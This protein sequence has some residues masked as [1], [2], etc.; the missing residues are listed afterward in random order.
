MGDTKDGSSIA[1]QRA[2]TD[3]DTST[4]HIGF[5]G[6]LFGQQPANTQI[7]DDALAVSAVGTKDMLLNIRNM[8]EM[9]VDDVAIP[10]ADITSVPDD[11]TLD[12]VVA[13]FRQS[14]NSR[15]PVFSETLDNPLG[16]VHLKDIA[17]N[18]GFGGNGKFDLKAIIRPLIYVPP[19]MPLGALLQKMQSER[20]HMAL[21]IDEYGGVEGL[22]T[23]EDLIEEIVGEIEDEHD[24]EEA[25]LW[26]EEAPEVFI[27]QARAPLD[28]F[29]E[30]AGVDL[31]PDDLDEE[32]DTL[33]GLVF[34]LIGR[35]PSR[36]EC[37]RDGH[38]HEFEV[39]DADARRIKSL[40][41]RLNAKRP[42]GQA[43]E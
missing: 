4:P 43:A 27:A 38:G 15:L 14:A 37:I 36:G 16:L 13:A 23:L 28:E 42:I 1:A 20:V 19:S 39:I 41:V 8:H 34:M 12:E 25:Q 7:N 10:T 35:V 6:R 29:E 24:I 17:L 2:Q 33:G 32:V 31:L 40:R 18:Y 11:A 22:V 21:V 9:R 5:W 26:S 3:L 30:A